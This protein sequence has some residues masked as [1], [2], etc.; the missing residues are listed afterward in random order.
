MEG[1]HGSLHG[2][3]WCLVAAW[4]WMGQLLAWGC[5]VVGGPAACL[6][7]LG[8]VN[9]SLH[10]PSLAAGVCWAP[11]LSVHCVRGERRRTGPQLR[12]SPPLG[13]CHAQHS[14]LWVPSAD[15]A[16]RCHPPPADGG[17]RAG[18]DQGGAGEGRG[19][20]NRAGPPK[21]GLRAG[22]RR[23]VLPVLHPYPYPKGTLP[24]TL[25]SPYSYP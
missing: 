22:G 14:A 1:E 13:A 17:G 7:V 5:L 10:G 20:A 6:V 15:A 24:R 4:W 3:A 23:L 8:G 18:P 11:P 19:P 2:P 16:L 9:A 25:P 12:G 21:G